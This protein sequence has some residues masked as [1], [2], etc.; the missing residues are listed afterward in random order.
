M[1]T[2]IFLSIDSY[3][4]LWFKR[5]RFFNALLR[6]PHSFNWAKLWY[7]FKIVITK[8]KFYNFKKVQYYMYFIKV[9]F[10]RHLAVTRRYLAWISLDTK[11]R[12]IA[13]HNFDATVYYRRT[14]ISRLYFAIKLPVVK[15]WQFVNAF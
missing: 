6:F 5:W 10:W 14:I 12:N 1:R 9:K 4:H 11:F 15:H 8:T 3:D 7:R 13:W 2:W